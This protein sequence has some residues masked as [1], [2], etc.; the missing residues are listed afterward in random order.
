M[1]RVVFVDID[2]TLTDK[3]D[4]IPAKVVE[5]LEELEK[6]GFI[7]VLAS[8][9]AYPIAYGLAR[10]LATSGW[11][12]AENGGVY[13]RG[14][15][16]RTVV[17]C[18]KEELEELVDLHL[19]DY[20]RD[21]WQNIFRF[22]DLAYHPQVG[23]SVEEAVSVSRAVLEPRG[24]E[25]LDSG[26]A[27]HIHPVGVNKGAAI[28]DLLEMMGIDKAVTFAVGDSEVDIAMFERVD[29][30]IVLGNAPDHVKKYGKIIVDKGF[31]EGFLE[32]QRI[33]REIKL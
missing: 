26:F 25:V 22:V 11:V 27:I 24:Y 10:Y 16:I 23:K 18:E 7:V 5:A 9:N 15:D 1:E 8:G 20:L 13:G 14:G 30:P 6:D 17:L 12:I 19:R 4:K 33:I 21:S 2:G 28:P 3:N 29:Y 31:A 32:A